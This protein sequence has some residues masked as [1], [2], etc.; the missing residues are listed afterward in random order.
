MPKWVQSQNKDEMWV[1]E[2][3]QGTQGWTVWRGQVNVCYHGDLRLVMGGSA[4]MMAAGDENPAARD[5]E[6]SRNQICLVHWRRL[7][8]AGSSK[9]TSPG[10]VICSA[11][12]SWES[13][14]SSNSSETD[15]SVNC[16]WKIR[17]LKNTKY[18]RGIDTVHV[19]IGCLQR[20]GFMRSSCLHS[21]SLSKKTVNYDGGPTRQLC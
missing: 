21:Q 16:S 6:S 20:K 11:Y 13:T 17:N 15:R 4:E 8:G 9:P 3:A 1:S 12:G 10:D 14:C 7:R 2:G 5:L 18:S 19:L